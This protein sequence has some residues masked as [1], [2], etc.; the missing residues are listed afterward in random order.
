MPQPMRSSA[1]WGHAAAAAPAR[2]T[3]AVYK[4]PAGAAIFAD[5]PANFAAVAAVGVATSFTSTLMDLG[6]GGPRSGW[7]WAGSVEGQGGSAGQPRD[8]PS[9][10]S[11]PA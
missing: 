11:V 8:V 2:S 4:F 3:L 10:L 6:D 5:A 1:K 7:G 9:R